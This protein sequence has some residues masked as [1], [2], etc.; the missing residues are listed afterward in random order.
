M[1]PLFRTAAAVS[2]ALIWSGPLLA[3]DGGSDRSTAG[4]PIEAYARLT[5]AGGT[6]GANGS[7]DSGYP[8][9]AFSMQDDPGATALSRTWM[10]PAMTSARVGSQGQGSWTFASPASASYVPDPITAS[11]ET[12]ASA[13]DPTRPS[14]GSFAPSFVPV[15]A[16]YRLGQTKQVAFALG[17]PTASRGTQ[18]WRAANGGSDV[19]TSA[20]KVAYAMVIPA[21]DQQSSTVVAVGAFARRPDAISQYGA[22]GRVETAVMR[23]N[24]SGWGFGGVAALMQA[25]DQD[26]G[27]LGGRPMNYNASSG[28]SLGLG[29]QVS[30]GTRWL[31]SKVDVQCRWLYE[32]RG[33]TGHTEEPVLVTANL[34]F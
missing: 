25:P 33:P 9:A 2:L 29:P 10:F 19:W 5:P 21:S 32:P 3:G 4:L 34:H 31:G 24:L 18:N 12:T 13:N 7:Y 20:P 27:G 17:I 15:F 14:Y 30:W 23:Q 1:C 11:N 6:A 22:V 8:G 28:S 16:S 26:S